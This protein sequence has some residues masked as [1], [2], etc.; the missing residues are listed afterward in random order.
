M[1]RSNRISGNSVRAFV[2]RN[3]GHVYY[4]VLA[5]FD[6]MTD[7]VEQ[8]SR[9]I[10]L[11]TM[12]LEI[13]SGIGIQGPYII[14]G[15]TYYH[16]YEDDAYLGYQ[17]SNCCERGLILVKKAEL[18]P[19]TARAPKSKSEKLKDLKSCQILH[20]EGRN[21]VKVDRTFYEYAGENNF[22]LVSLD[23]EMQKHYSALFKENK[24]VTVYSY[25]ELVKTLVCDVISLK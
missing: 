18:N 8:V 12:A 4:Q 24:P 20:F 10:T 22:V 16:D 17:Y 19:N 2:R 6:G 25:E 11:A 5:E 23:R 9:P 15:S 13:S 1:A 14:N 7:C 21:F 3:E